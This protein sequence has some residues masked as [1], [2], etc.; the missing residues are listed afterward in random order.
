MK[1]NK[2]N[3]FVLLLIVMVPGVRAQVS[4]D[5]LLRLAERN[6]PDIR[7]AYQYY[8]NARIRTNLYPENPEIEY[9]HLWGSSQSIGTRNDLSVSQ[10]FDFP[11]VYINRS[12]L[13]NSD[14]DKADQLFQGIV[15]EVLLKTQH[16]WIDNVFLNKRRRVLEK[17]MEETVHELN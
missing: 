6:S 15:Q 10:S 12:K 5:S 11:G 4:L 2:K 13:S 8:E 16:H 3:V 14:I 1:M 17:R 9:G 7:T